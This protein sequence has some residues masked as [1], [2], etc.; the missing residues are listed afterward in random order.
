MST[1]DREARRLE[2]TPGSDSVGTQSLTSLLT[3]M[4]FCVRTVIAPMP[5]TSVIKLLIHVH[6]DRFCCK[7]VLN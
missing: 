5:V 7:K 2:L 6:N 1:R 3:S 4:H